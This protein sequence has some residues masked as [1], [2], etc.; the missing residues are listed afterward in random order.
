MKVSVLINNYGYAPYLEACINSVLNQ[1]YPDVEIIFYDD[2]SKDNSLEVMAQFADRVK[3]IAN[4]NYGKYASFNQAHAVYEAFKVSSGEIICLLDSDD[5]FAPTKIE[6]VVAEFK[7]D[8]DLSLVQH[9]ML[10]IDTEGKPNGKIK[11]KRM[12]ITDKPLEMLRKT[13]RF[14]QF[15]MQTSALSFRRSF[16]EK[17]LPM[18]ENVY[19]NLWVDL[20]LTRTAMYAGKFKTL[21]EP[22]TEYRVHPN[23]D[24]KKL[25]NKAYYDETMQQQQD[26]MD[27]LA[28]KYGQPIITQK[29]GILNTL[30]TFFAVAFSGMEWQAKKLF[31][32]DFIKK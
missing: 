26:F 18:D 13:K 1:T 8:K 23:N 14:D 30:G 7:R 24:S 27:E 25:L 21:I 4:P 5:N 28:R 22:L 29:T 16:L 15:F 32:T 20:R 31:F 12:I 10:E 6:K 2:G 19:Q 9:R 3:I 17:H 11:K